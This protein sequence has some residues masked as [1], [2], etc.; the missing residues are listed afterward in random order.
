MKKIYCLI[1][2][3]V[4]LAIGFVS[5]N[6]DL[7]PQI[8]S[9]LTSSNFPKTDGDINSMLTS[10]YANITT[11][12]GPTDPTSGEYKAG[13]YAS[14]YGWFHLSSSCSD[15]MVDM[16]F[17]QYRLAWGSAYDTY[18]ALYSRVQ[19]VAQITSFLQTVQ[20]ANISSTLKVSATADAKCL[21]AW[22][23]FMLYDWYG[24]VAVKYDP[25]TLTSD[26]ILPRP[27]K[28]TYFNW[29]VSDLNDAIP[30]LRSKTNGTSDWGRVNKGLALTLLMKIYM[31][32][33][34]WAKAEAVGNQLLTQGYSLMPNYSDVFSKSQ[35]NEVIWAVPCGTAVPNHFITPNIPGNCSKI[36]GR[37]MPGGWGGYY[38]PWSFYDKYPTGD[39]RLLTIASSFYDAQ[40]NL[41]QRGSNNQ[42]FL[43]YGAIPVK[44]LIDSAAYSVGNYD[45]V[46]FRFGDVLLSMA[47]IE[48]ALNGPTANAIGYLKKVTDRANTVI[49]ASAKASQQAFSDFLLDERGREL[50]WEG[51]RRQDLIRFNKLISWGVSAGL[52]ATNAMVLYPIP[53]RVIIQ[54]GG[55]ITNNPGY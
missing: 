48:N 15:E 3:I 35:N 52:P 47:E 30:N 55:V 22:F 16:W 29:M 17:P 36:L 19:Q 2:L 14:L 49:P 24:P 40:G 41:F 12:W 32:D 18:D 43:Y 13:V 44:Y 23:M 54:S 9:T 38:M 4:L 25:A 42:G 33:H 21:R 34:Q 6:K 11:D 8:Y 51:W 10:F 39:T 31:N 28:D 50:Y 1:V 53:P 27:S 37:G 20:N 7:N 46:A 26:S 45:Q 5:C